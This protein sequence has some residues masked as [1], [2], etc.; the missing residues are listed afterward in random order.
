MGGVSLADLDKNAQPVESSTTALVLLGRDEVVILADRVLNT[1]TGTEDQ[2][3]TS[4]RLLLKLGSAYVD[5]TEPG[6]PTHDLPLVLTEAE[7]WLLR[8]KITSGDKTANDA[9]F[10]LAIVDD[11]VI[12]R[13]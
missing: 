11:C 4:Y 2:Q 5:Q 6:A 9:Q 3:V 10:G 13:T 8:S 7:L 12:M 1:D